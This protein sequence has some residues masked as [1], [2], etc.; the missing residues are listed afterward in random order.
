MAKKVVILGGGIGGLSAAHELAEVGGFEVHVYDASRAVGGKAQ[1][2]F[3]TGTGRGGR[4]DLP[5]EHGFRFFPAWYKHIPHTMGRIPTPGGG[6]VADR[7][8][9]CTQMGLAEVDERAVY[10]LPRHRPGSLGDFFR[11]IDAVADFFAGTGVSVTDLGRFGMKMLDYMLLCEERRR[12]DY[13]RVSFFDFVEGH[14]YTQRFQSYLNSSRF[15]V[16]M[17][18][19]NGSAC[20]IAN[21]ALHILLD[22]RRPAGSNDR[23]LDGPT[24]LRWLDPWEKY[25]RDRGVSFHL[26]R[27]VETFDVDLSARRI[28]GVRV[29][30]EPEP[31]TADYYVAALPLERT[32]ACISDEMAQ[33]DES[34]LRLR[35]AEG[36]TSWM[37]GAQELRL[38]LGAPRAEVRRI[39]EMASVAAVE[40]QQHLARPRPVG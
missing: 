5:G 16:A 29:A 20:T 27:R 13:E 12:A 35:G 7:L 14:R 36:M 17:D 8:V 21:K 30:G 3:L 1:S 24:T 9:G 18:A 38:A 10:R 28:R 32:Q 25:L 40:D 2:Q 37:V 23:V 22:F 11:V 15:M 6:T 31:V 26:G 33:L 4:R 19:K 34:L 39:P